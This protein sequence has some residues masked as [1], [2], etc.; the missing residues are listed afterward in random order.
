MTTT[1]DIP[2]EVLERAMRA[3]GTQS[4]QEAVVRALEEYTRRRSQKE[5]IQHLGTFEDFM[6]PEELHEMRRME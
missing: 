3:A 2:D 5:L 6:T 1:I 4:P